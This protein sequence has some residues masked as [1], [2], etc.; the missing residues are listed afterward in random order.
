LR[1]PN[2][3]SDDDIKNITDQ[4]KQNEE[5]LWEKYIGVN[6]NNNCKEADQSVAQAMGSLLKKMVKISHLKR[7]ELDQV[8]TEL[9]SIEKSMQDEAFP[10]DD[11]A[12]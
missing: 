10:E 3:P 12:E 9:Q 1:N 6:F 7:I 4:E 11:V 5:F 2:I 8:I